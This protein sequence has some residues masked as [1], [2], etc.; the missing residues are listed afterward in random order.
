MVYL[1]FK[2]IYLSALAVLSLYH[3]LGSSLA[4]NYILHI[5]SY[6]LLLLQCVGSRARLA[7]VVVA[8]GSSIVKNSRALEKAQAQ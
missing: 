8:R 2:I 4:L 7:S 5:K 3:C 1:F 6:Y